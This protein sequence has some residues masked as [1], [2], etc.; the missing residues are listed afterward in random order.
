MK[1]QNLDLQDKLDEKEKIGGRAYSNGVR[2]MSNSYTAKAFYTREGQ[3]KVKANKLKKQESFSI[4]KKIPIIRGIV[5]LF[6]AVLMFLKEGVNNPKKY[7]IIFLIILLEL[8]YWLLPSSTADG[9]L[10]IVLI[11]YIAIPLILLLRFRKTIVEILKFHG[12]EHKTVHYYENDCSGDIKSYSRLHRRCGSNIV[13]YYLL[14]SL[15]S[16]FLFNKNN[17]FLEILY[18]GIAYEAIRYTPEKLL[19]LPYFFQRIVTKEPDEKHIRAAKNALD[20][21]IDRS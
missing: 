8:I 19:F 1:K 11:L 7:W 17:F 15:V 21:L 13:F 3:L 4:I 18:L 6:F 9:F 16:I 2:L 20:V 10:D 5:S 12:A 14:I